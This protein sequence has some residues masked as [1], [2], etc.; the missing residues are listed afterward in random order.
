MELLLLLL[1]FLLAYDPV[2]PRSTGGTYRNEPPKTKRPEGTPVGQRAK[3]R[4]VAD[5]LTTRD[6]EDDEE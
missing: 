3:V 6:P 2:W 4:A 5:Y 1:V